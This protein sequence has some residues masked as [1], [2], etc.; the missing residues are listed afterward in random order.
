MSDQPVKR[1]WPTSGMMTPVRSEILSP[2]VLATDY[3]RDIKAL[4][5]ERDTLQAQ[6]TEANRL[7]RENLRR[8]DEAVPGVY[9]DCFLC[10]DTR[11]HLNLPKE[12]GGGSCKL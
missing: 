6:L 10:N 9:C 5:V 2:Y 12:V 3:D 7:L 1:W 11:A 8:S 4:E